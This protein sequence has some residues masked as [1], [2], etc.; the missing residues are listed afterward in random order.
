MEQ[1]YLIIFS[2][3]LLFFPLGS[4]PS[5]QMMYLKANVGYLPGSYIPHY[6]VMLAPCLAGWIAL[7]SIGVIILLHVAPQ[8]HRNKFS[9]VFPT[10]M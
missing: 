8:W 10:I 1:F 4:F 5:D 6:I 3:T 9:E 7:S 2:E